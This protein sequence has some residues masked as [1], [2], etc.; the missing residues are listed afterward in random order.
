[1]F[2]GIVEELGTVRR[3]VPNA[4]GAQLEIACSVVLEDAR[5]GDSIAVNGVYSQSGPLSM[6]LQTPDFSDQ[7]TVSGVTTMSDCFH[8]DQNRRTAI[9]KSLS[10]MLR[11]G[12]GRRRFRQGG[13]AA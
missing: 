4:T 6:D 13:L 9:Q 5:I 2:T 11:L 8:C 3:V 1:M 12:R 7:M 10:K